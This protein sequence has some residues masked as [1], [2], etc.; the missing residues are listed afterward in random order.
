MGYSMVG[1]LGHRVD[2]SFFGRSRESVSHKVRFTLDV[3]NISGKFSNITQLILL[4]DRLRICLFVDGWNK[5][6]VIGKECE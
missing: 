5:T 6:L 3:A 4:L 1:D 2:I